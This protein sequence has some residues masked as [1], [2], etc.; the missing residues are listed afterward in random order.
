[1]VMMSSVYSLPHSYTNFEQRRNPPAYET[2][3]RRLDVIEF[4]AVADALGVPPGRLL[5][6][7]RG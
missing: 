4:L 3:D 1:M 6:K 7:V 5:A 2:G